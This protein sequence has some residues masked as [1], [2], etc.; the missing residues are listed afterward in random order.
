MQFFSSFLTDTS[1]L[2]TDIKDLVY[3][4]IEIQLPISKGV[5]ITDNI[6]DVMAGCKKTY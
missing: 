3:Q 1:H 2:V 5:S 4:L 6:F